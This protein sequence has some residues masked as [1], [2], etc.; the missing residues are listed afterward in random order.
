ME[1]ARVLVPVHYGQLGDKKT[2]DET[3][4]AKVIRSVG[5]IPVYISLDTSAQERSDLRKS[6]HGLWIRGGSDVD[7]GKYGQVHHSKVSGV[8]TL[9]DEM[10]LEEIDKAH[11]RDEKPVI[12]ICRG[13]QAMTVATG[14]R[15]N[16]H[17]PD[18]VPHEAHGVSVD[19][20]DSLKKKAYHDVLIEPGTKAAEIFG[21]DRLSDVTSL[22]H[23][24]IQDPGNIL[25]VSGKSPEG[26]AE[27]AEHYD[28]QAPFF[29]GIQFHPELDMREMGE[30]GSPKVIFEYFAAAVKNHVSDK[31]RA[32]TAA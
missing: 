12:G 4:C 11:N 27:I 7:P 23:Q 29:M 21:T 17:L 25:I 8:D 18:I 3:E 31:V 1:R 2:P 9:F 14:G 26:I 13:V 20:R 22:H 32:T 30:K 15:L 16:Q 28:P 24:S 6:T 10:Q 5:L 19:E